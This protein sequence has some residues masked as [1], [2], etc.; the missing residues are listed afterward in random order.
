MGIVVDL[1]LFVIMALSIFIGYKRGLIKCAINVLSFFIAII[2]VIILTN[3][4]SNFIINNTKIDDNIKQS[5]S[6]NL[7][8]ENEENLKLDSENSSVPKVIADYINNNVIDSAKNAAVSV[9]QAIAENITNII[10]KVCVAI[11]LYLII[12]IALIFAKFIADYVG[13]IPVIKQFNEV[14]GIIYGIISGIVFIYLI[15]AIISMISPLIANSAFIKTINDSFIGSFIYNN[16][17][18]LK[19]FIL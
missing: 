7:H 8:F 14:G 16:N 19:L 1:V 12:R 3:P 4:I 11:L 13:K 2:L 17:L 6:N 15:F 5:I 10:I 18:L 9:K